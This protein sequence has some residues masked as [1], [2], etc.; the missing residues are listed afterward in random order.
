MWIRL[1]SKVSL[2][3]SLIIDSLSCRVSCSVK[4]VPF[5]CLVTCLHIFC[6]FF[7]SFYVILLTCI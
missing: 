7:I 2:L 5:G 4:H 3:F 1:D 6:Y